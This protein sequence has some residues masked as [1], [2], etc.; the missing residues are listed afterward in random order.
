MNFFML[1]YWIH[2]PVGYIR[3]NMGN[4]RSNGANNN[5]Q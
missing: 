3:S 5:I 1:L 4:I 2:V